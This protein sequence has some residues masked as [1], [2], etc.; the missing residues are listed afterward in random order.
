M[1]SGLLTLNNPI[2]RICAAF[3]SGALLVLATPP[4]SLGFLAWFALVPLF[5][6]LEKAES[7]KERFRIG[8]VFGLIY[9]MGVIYWI[10]FN[11]GADWGARL[12][13]AVGAI[14][15]LTFWFG[16]IAL[17]HGWLLEKQGKSGHYTAILLWVSQEVIRS[18]GELGFPWPYFSLSQTAYLPILQLGAL[19]GGY[20]V[21][22]WIIALNVILVT[23]SRRRRTFP[24]YLGIIVMVWITG[25][26]RISSV[27]SSTMA[28][29]ALIQGNIDPR[30]K[31][32]LG[33]EHSLDIYQALTDSIALENP[34]LIIWPET[35]AP[36]Y[37]QR[38][39]RW[40]NHI[41][42]FV[43]SLE[44][45]LAT[46]A[47][48]YEYDGDTPVRYNAAFLVKPGGRG[49]F[50]HYYKVHLV[51]FGERVPFQKLFPGLGKLNFGQAEFRPGEGVTGWK[52]PLANGEVV[53]SPLIC[54]EAI[55]PDLWLSS[56]EKDADF[57]INLTND[58]WLRGT[59]EPA[60]H[61]MLSR[62]R[63]VETGHSIVRATNT[64]ISAIIGPTGKLLKVLPENVRGALV[65]E[66]PE[67][68]GT[69][70]VK[71]GYLFGRFVLLFL[72]ISILSTWMKSRFNR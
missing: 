57:V 9:H 72:F 26:V 27:D 69:L 21:T 35:A 3:L 54:Y 1:R 19:G 47:S 16:L 66:I 58:G 23:G 40:R 49:R 70:Y 37:L 7:T 65:N 56:A 15:I 28:K 61:L 36:V 13:S 42:Q 39:I 10:A 64:G 2:S 30:D 45:P 38:S 20:L 67:P 11:T 12:G 55:F 5:L 53:A 24:V 50:E 43:D 41:Q 29:V 22:A 14:L 59:S 48:Q 4:I 33:P 44:I 62:M 6:S 68:V 18:H 8:L 51:P 63:C 17:V 46:G 60:Q 34:D 25:V 31:W 52:V 71:G 32:E